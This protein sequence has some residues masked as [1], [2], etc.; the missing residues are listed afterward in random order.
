MEVRCDY[1]TIMR[2]QMISDLWIC[3]IIYA[4]LNGG[5]SI[6][7]C[8]ALKVEWLANWTGC[9]KT[10]QWPNLRWNPDI[11]PGTGEK[12][13]RISCN[14]ESVVGLNPRPPKHK[15]GVLSAW[16]WHAVQRLMDE[17]ENTVPLYVNCFQSIIKTLF[18]YYQL[19]TQISCSFT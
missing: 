12:P 19:D 14:N 8:I 9:R 15:E 3:L 16:L 6:A 7:E 2:F 10:K 5:V 13:Q 1:R 11:S 18:Y 4:V 17:W